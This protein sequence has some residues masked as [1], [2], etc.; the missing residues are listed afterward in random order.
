MHLRAEGDHHSGLFGVVGR[1]PYGPAEVGL[2][3]RVDISQ[4]HEGITSFSGHRNT[5]TRV[6]MESAFDKLKTAVIHQLRLQHLDYDNPVLL[7]TDV[8]QQSCSIVIPEAQAF[9]LTPSISRSSGG[10]R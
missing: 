1:S 6:E 9:S 7:Q 10:R 2:G 5:P 3:E 4:I 8:G